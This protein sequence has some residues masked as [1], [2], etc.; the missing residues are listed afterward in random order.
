TQYRDDYFLNS[1]DKIRYFFEEEAF[2]ESG[3]LKVE[4]NKAINK[5]GHALHEL[6]PDFKNFSLNNKSIHQIAKNLCLKNPQ[7]LQSML[8]LKQPYIGGRVS[9]HQDSTF[10]YTKPL[11]A[12][13]F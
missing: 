10:L 13:G 11:S 9:P 6:D 1:G 3:K 4:K 12:I 8:I 7:I 2:D 5:I